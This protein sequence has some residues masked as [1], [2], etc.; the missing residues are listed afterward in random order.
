VCVVGNGAGRVGVGVQAGRDIGTAVKRALV[1][2]KKNMVTVPLVGAGT[3]PHRVE[4]WFKAAGV[5]MLPAREGEGP[6]RRGEP[7]G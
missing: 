4:T 5:V 6:G 7:G 2:A 3:L 1:D